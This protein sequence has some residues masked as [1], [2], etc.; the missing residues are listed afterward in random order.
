LKE[1]PHKPFIPAAFVAHAIEVMRARISNTSSPR[2]L[3]MCCVWLTGS[4][5]APVIE[6]SL[7]PSPPSSRR[8]RDHD[9][10]RQQHQSLRRTSRSLR[11]PPL[12]PSVATP[13]TCATSSTH[14]GKM[15][16]LRAKV[17]GVEPIRFHVRRRRT[18]PRTSECKFHRRIQH[19][20]SGEVSRFQALHTRRKE[21]P[22]RV[23][24]RPRGPGDV[25]LRRYN[26]C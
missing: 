15:R 16:A 3:L 12:A 9:G 6:P 22:A 18:P 23:K 21:P 1:P 20:S 7:R 14:G 4:L 24:R 25:L 8:L 13:R 11:H 17:G 19:F 10:L 26:P 2:V 5:N